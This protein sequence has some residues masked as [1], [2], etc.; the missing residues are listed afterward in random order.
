MGIFDLFRKKRDN[1][2]LK[3]VNEIIEI[4]VDNLEEYLNNIYQEKIKLL[5]SI[6]LDLLESFKS[7]TNKLENNILSL[8]LAEIKNKNLQERIVQI[9]KDNRENYIKI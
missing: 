9:A 7:E 2:K 4:E 3:K 5:S 6:S 1:S 8:S